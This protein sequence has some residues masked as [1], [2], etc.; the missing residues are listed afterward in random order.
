MEPYL[1]SDKTGRIASYTG[2]MLAASYNPPAIYGA[3][4][5][6]GGGKYYFDFTDCSLGDLSTGMSVRMSFRRKYMDKKRDISGYF[7]KAV[8]VK[9]EK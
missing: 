1:F 4:V 6:E 5:F 3:V 2:D 9:E 8:P 7:W